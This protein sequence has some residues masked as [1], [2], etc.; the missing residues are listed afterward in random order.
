MKTALNAASTITQPWKC[1][2]SFTSDS[3]NY[4]SRSSPSRL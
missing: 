3:E 2:L 1:S 4:P